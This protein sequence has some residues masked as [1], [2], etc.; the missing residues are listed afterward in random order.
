MFISV[1]EAAELTGKSTTTI[2]R[3][4]NKRKNTQ[5]VRKEDN[6]FLIDKDFLLA[7][8]PDDFDQGILEG[9][10]EQPVGEA[11]ENQNLNKNNNSVNDEPVIILEKSNLNFSESAIA[12]SPENIEIEKGSTLEFENKKDFFQ[13]LSSREVL[14]GVSVS[15][16]IIILFIYLLSFFSA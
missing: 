10:L 8:Y 13:N 9:V 7:T 11:F 3:L 15:L 2:Y 12:S 6:K 16:L 5:F 1:R 4:C 14:I